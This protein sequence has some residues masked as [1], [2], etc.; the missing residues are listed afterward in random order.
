MFCSPARAHTL[1]SGSLSRA[2][3]GGSLGSCYLTQVWPC[4]IIGPMSDPGIL[5]PKARLT[6]L[7]FPP[8]PSFPPPSFLTPS[9][10]LSLPPSPKAVADLILHSRPYTGALQFSD[11][12]PDHRAPS[13]LGVMSAVRR[14]SSLLGAW[15]GQSG[16]AFVPSCILK[17][18]KDL[19]RKS[20]GNSTLG[21]GQLV[22]ASRAF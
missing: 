10:S 20:R 3:G 13:F 18:S 1:S 8:P 2:R 9:L 12:A 5:S 22:W 4:P 7:L 21:T 16:E 17:D 11:A 19:A 14:K 6:S 15:G